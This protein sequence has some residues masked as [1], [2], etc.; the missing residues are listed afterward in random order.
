M[1]EGV[2][3]FVNVAFSF[4]NISGEL[5]GPE[6]SYLDLAQRIGRAYVGFVATG[7][8]NSFHGCKNGTIENE[9]PSFLTWPKYRLSNPTN[10]VMNSNGSWVEEDTWRK[11]GMSF[12]NQWHVN[13]EL[14]A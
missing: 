3:H 10:M 14:L 13:R 1:I 5:L 7:N 4:Q 9:V 11:E 2:K 6:Q 8:A 12:I